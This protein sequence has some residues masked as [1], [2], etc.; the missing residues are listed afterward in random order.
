MR[1]LSRIAAGCLVLALTLVAGSGQGSAAAPAIAAPAAEDQQALIGCLIEQLGDKD[2]DRREAAE[3]KLAEIGWPALPALMKAAGSKDPEI[4]LRAERAWTK[5]CPIR[6]TITTDRPQYLLGEN[7]IVH[8][9]MKNIGTAPAPCG[10]GAQFPTLRIDDAYHAT[11][12]P[13]DEQ[14]KPLPGQVET[15]PIPQITD[16]PMGTGSLKPGE[17]HEQELYLIRYLRFTEPGRYLIRIANVDHW[18]PTKEFAFGETVLTLKAPTPAEARQVFERMKK[19][20]ATGPAG[21]GEMP[22]GEVADFEGMLNPVYLPILLEYAG[23]GDDDALTAL[24][25]MQTASSVEALVGLVDQA[26]RTAT[27]S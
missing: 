2:F 1:N 26:V 20:P 19:L 8:V 17:T 9:S 3:A 7:I 13:V 24:G 10:S 25:R 5:V 4:A 11:A 23:K 22:T 21:P 12:T 16:G 27:S 15:W 6:V 18:N 14:S